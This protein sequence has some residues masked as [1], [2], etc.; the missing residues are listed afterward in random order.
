VNAEQ[1]LDTLARLQADVI[2]TGWERER[3]QRRAAR[4]AAI[5]AAD[6]HPL[7]VARDLNEAAIAA[8]DRMLDAVRHHRLTQAHNSLTCPICEG[9]KSPNPAD[10]TCPA[11]QAPAGQPCTQPTNTGRRP[12]RWHHAMRGAL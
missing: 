3:E 6:L 7:K 4:M 10:Y 2:Q 8:R 1:I 11:C 5:T 9:P 12:V